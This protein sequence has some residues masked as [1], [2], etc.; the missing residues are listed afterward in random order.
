[1][2]AAGWV[3]LD[4]AWPAGL[5]TLAYCWVGGGIFTLAYCLVGDTMGLS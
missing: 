3:V 4:L 5:V 2:L 1:M